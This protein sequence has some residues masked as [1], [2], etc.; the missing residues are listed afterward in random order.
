MRDS[1]GEFVCGFSHPY[2]SDDVV[3]TELRALLDGMNLCRT[4][5]LPNVCIESDATLVVNM[6]EEMTQ[7]H[8]CYVYWRRRVKTI[9]H[10][11]GTMRFIYREQNKVADQLAKNALGL[12]EKQ[13]FVRVRDLATSIQKLIFLDRIGIPNFRSPCK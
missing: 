7:P 8:W 12:S 11:F 5:G 10:Y 1:Q 9:R 3:E 4:L 2:N 6:L 13:E